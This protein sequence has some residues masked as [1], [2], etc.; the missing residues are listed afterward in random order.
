[1]ST[2][3]IDDARAFRGFLDA[4]P[5]GGDALSLDGCP[6]PWQHQ[7]ATDAGREDAPARE[8]IADLPREHG[9]PTLP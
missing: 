6:V 2:G 8:A 9:L 4:R 5:A 7:N 1:M 3:Q